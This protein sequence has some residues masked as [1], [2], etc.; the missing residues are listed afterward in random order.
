LQTVEEQG[1]HGVELGPDS[2]GLPFGDVGGV[3]EAGGGVEDGVRGCGRV[4]AGEGA[5]GEDGPQLAQEIRDVLGGNAAVLGRQYPVGGEQFRVVA[6]F[7]LLGREHRGEPGTQPL[8]RERVPPATA[9]RASRSRVSQRR[10]TASRSACN[11]LW[12]LVTASFYGC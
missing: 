9:A 10:V 8:R 12:G 11:L 6:G 7:G 1:A 3:V 4:G 5:V 2:G